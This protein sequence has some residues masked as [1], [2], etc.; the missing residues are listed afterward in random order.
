MRSALSEGALISA[1]V[2]S[3]FADQSVALHARSAKYGQVRCS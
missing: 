2:Q 3:L 1:E